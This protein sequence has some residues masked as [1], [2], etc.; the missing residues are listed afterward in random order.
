MSTRTEPAARAD[1]HTG[2]ATAR[3]RDLLAAEWIKLWS[4]RSTYGSLALIAVSAVL[5][6]ARAALADHRNWPGYS[7]ERRA[8]FDP[9]NDAFP[10]EGWLFVILAAGALGTVMIAGEY[11][12]GQ[13]RTTFLAVPDR[14]AVLTAKVV[15]LAAVMLV[16]GVVAA[17]A[18]FWVSQAIL[19]DRHAGA[20]IGEPQALRAAAA[21]ALLLP[22]CALIGLGVGALVRH[23]A[24]AIVITTTLLLLAPLAFDIN[25]RWTAAIHNALPVP[26]WER[27]VGNPW[28]LPNHYVATVA[29]SWAVFAVWPL[30]AALVAAV[31]VHRREP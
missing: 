12:S 27:L 18:S 22:V 4:L 31:V 17:A 24:P 19:A 25:N 23:T 8:A 14:R 5:F 3:F 6:S 1:R 20:S 16:V 15:V 28:V 26:A 21:S 30:V 9:V 7:A 10:T 13:F 11:A 2:A 29:G